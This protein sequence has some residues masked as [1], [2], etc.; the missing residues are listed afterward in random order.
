MPSL[1][2]RVVCVVI[3]S[4][5]HYTAALP[6]IFE[7][8]FTR[9]IESFLV[10]FKVRGCILCIYMAIQRT[11]VDYFLVIS[12]RVPEYHEQVYFIP[13]LIPTISVHTSNYVAGGRPS[14]SLFSEMASN[15]FSFSVISGCRSCHLTTISVA[16]R[17][18]GPFEA[19]NAFM[20]SAPFIMG[21]ISH[22]SSRSSFLMYARKA[23]CS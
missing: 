7:F 13:A 10:D 12:K 4:V 9:V 23:S 3:Y 11:E 16:K 1:I 5:L 8:N 22:T 15:A 2:S 20:I 6:S 21:F 18:H 19:F 14:S 17:I